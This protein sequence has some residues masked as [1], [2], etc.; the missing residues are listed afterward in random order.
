MKLKE[1][2]KL[3]EGKRLRPYKDSLG[4]LTVGYGRNLDAVPFSDHEINV[5]FDTDFERALI[6]AQ[7]FA[8]YDR[9]NDA[10]KGVI[11]EMVFQMGKW[12][13]WKFKKFLAAAA[14]EDWQK[15]HY[16]MLNSQWAS[17]TPGRAKKLANIFR[18]GKL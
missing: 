9:L 11:I 1:R 13:V 17:Q 5:M 2:I 6:A 14:K 8:A 12:G 15:A 18:S 10:R 3:H 4:V 16:E 7:S